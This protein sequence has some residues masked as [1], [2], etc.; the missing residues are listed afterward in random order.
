MIQNKI[1]KEHLTPYQESELMFK[2]VYA[3]RKN[4]DTFR[5]YFALQTP[6]YQKTIKDWHMAEQ[7]IILS[8]MTE[9][10]ENVD[11]SDNV[12]V[13]RHGRYT[14]AFIHKH[15]F[16][17]I[18]YVMEGSVINKIND[19]EILMKEGDICLLSPGVYHCLKETNDSLIINI[20]LKHYVA[21]SVLSSFLIQKNILSSF[22]IQA[23][24]MNRSNRYLL[25]HLNGDTKIQSLIETLAEEDLITA[26]F[27]KDEQHSSLKEALLNLIFNYIIRF[28]AQN[29]EYEEIIL[30]NSHLIIEIQDYLANN[31]NSATLK[32]LAQHFNYSPSYL[33]R[34]IQQTAGTNFSKILRRIKI[35]KA[36]SLLNNTSL[37]INEISER[38]G[39]RSQRQFNRAFRDMTGTTP[40]EY[41]K[42]H[43]LLFI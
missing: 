34:L 42:Q 26:K 19:T 10:L 12:I 4:P 33:S 11:F 29:A 32:T 43:K 30:T 18:I 6:E 23:L 36:C 21:S 31:I 41:R 14:P 15:T 2:E 8:E 13:T 20:L 38:I 27:Q 28:H 9:N 25:F 3:A 37:S 24:Y 17:E 16:F 35:N 40:S 5:R 7:G 1:L 39:Y 22:F